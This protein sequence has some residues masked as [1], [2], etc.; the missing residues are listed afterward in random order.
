MPRPKDPNK[1]IPL[2]IRL[3]PDLREWVE[4]RIDDDDQ[5][6]SMSDLI[7]HALEQLRQTETTSAP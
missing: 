4:A 5:F 1:K 6:R 3:K 7:G 2:S